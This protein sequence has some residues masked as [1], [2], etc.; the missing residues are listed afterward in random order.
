[1]QRA[2]ATFAR[3]FR[4]ATFSPGAPGRAEPR[5][6]SAFRMRPGGGSNPSRYCL[7]QKMDPHVGHARGFRGTRVGWP[8]ERHTSFQLSGPVNRSALRSHLPCTCLDRRFMNETFLACSAGQGR[9]LFQRSYRSLCA[10]S[11]GSYDA[12]SHLIDTRLLPKVPPGAR[13]HFETFSYTVTRTMHWARAAPIQIND[14]TP[15]ARSSLH[16]P[17]PRRFRRSPQSRIEGPPHNKWDG[18]IG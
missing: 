9:T 5:S 11:Q 3:C 8:I 17:Q 15:V 14:L 1:M 13:S 18:E 2:T 12:Q 4:F 7:A 16:V 6:V 10:P